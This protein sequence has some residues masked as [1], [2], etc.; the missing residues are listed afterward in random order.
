MTRVQ[1]GDIEVDDGVLDRFRARLDAL[2]EVPPCRA[3]YAAAHVVMKSDY[4]DVAHGVDTPGS[5]DE[6]A[7]HIDWD[8]TADFRQHLLDQ[9]F[10]VA[11]AMDTAQR[12]QLGYPAARRLIRL[13]G[14]LSGDRGFIAGASTDH[15][16]AVDG[17]DDLVDGTLE[18]M[19]TIRG[20]GGMP[21]VLPMP[22]L[23]ANAADEET[24]VDVYGRIVDD[25]DG[26]LLI[27]WLGKAFAPS[28]DGYFPGD[29]FERIM[30]RDPE[31]VRGVKLSLLDDR[32]E[33]EVRRR[34]LSR[35][36]LV[37]T[38][39]DYHFGGLIL[40]SDPAPL[41]HVSLGGRAVPAGRFSHALLGI[42]DATAIPAG[43]ALRLLAHGLTDDYVEI[44]SRCEALADVI[45]EPP[46]A[47][48][49]AGLAF[50]GWLNG[51]QDQFLLINH[52]QRERDR[53]HYLRVAKLAS[54]AGAIRHARRAASRL[55]AWMA[56]TA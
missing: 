39:D 45:F 24:Y 30:A 42:F 35:G 6:I 47:R 3:A 27:H 50:V 2:G 14:E 15:L 56:D 33:V 43:V 36:Q 55:E 16:D 38:G 40:G 19:T 53:D 26:P 23:T 10:R 20:H 25:A 52:E 29:S 9:G 49:K 54:R 44:M 17:P 48:Y 37:F 8:R 7:R 11:E 1:V 41:R 28:L 4:Q 46:V 5:P 21:I 34:L 18:Q 13:C 51:F 12:F 32:F 31:K 22:W